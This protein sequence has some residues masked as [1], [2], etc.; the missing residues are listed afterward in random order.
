MLPINSEHT[1]ILPPQIF[2]QEKVVRH[3][4]WKLWQPGA[5]SCFPSSSS[6]L[7]CNCNHNLLLRKIPKSRKKTS[8][9]KSGLFIYPTPTAIKPRDKQQTVWTW[10][11]ISIQHK[12]LQKHTPTYPFCCFFSPL[13]Y[14]S[15]MGLP[16]LVLFHITIFLSI[17]FYSLH[18]L[19]C[20][21]RLFSL[22]SLEKHAF[23]SPYSKDLH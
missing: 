21:N 11:Y 16:V 4:I 22:F 19:L 20:M 23:S 10:K 5:A 1:V 15:H 12:A 6:S 17:L 14:F 2:S 18:M 13:Q 7:K 9:S 3:Y 8:E